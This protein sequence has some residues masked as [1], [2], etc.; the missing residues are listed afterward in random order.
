M[1]STLPNVSLVHWAVGLFAVLLFASDLYLFGHVL[2]A[3]QP[4]LKQPFGGDFVNYWAGPQI[5]LREVDSLYTVER[6]SQLQSMLYGSHVED[7]NMSYPPQALLLFSLVAFLPYMAGFVVWTGVGLIG[8]ISA[9]G[10]G[11]APNIR[12]ILLP[13]ALIVPA[14]LLNIHGGQNGYFTAGGALLVLYLLRKERNVAAG[15]VLGLLSFKPHI[16][17]LWPIMLLIER[18][19]K[20]IVAAAITVL[21]L[22][23]I[24]IEVYGINAWHDYLT[25]TTPLQWKITYEAPEGDKLLKVCDLAIPSVT[26]ALRILGAPLALNYVVQAAATL[27][28]AFGIGTAFFRRKLAIDHAAL[29]LSS[30]ALLATPYVATHDTLFLI[31]A[32]ILRVGRKTELT[33][34][35]AMLYGVGL[36]SAGILLWLNLLGLPAMPLWIALIFYYTWRE[37]RTA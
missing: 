16:F 22:V 1:K 6:Y 8:Y 10:Y 32:L 2:E 31:A 27:I 34:A 28:V 5:A 30:G 12:K 7:H 21:L 15:I 35:E 9:I 24:S 29:L 19:W 3:V 23:G 36:L 14:S 26:V 18:R 20:T 33:F 11:L 17:L 13:L 4:G 25:V 37:A